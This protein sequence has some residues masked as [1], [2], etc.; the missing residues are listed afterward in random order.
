MRTGTNGPHGMDAQVMELPNSLQGMRRSRVRPRS[1]TM[2]PIRHASIGKA[3]PLPRELR[4]PAQPP[5][6]ARTR[7]WGG[8]AAS[9]RIGRQRAALAGPRRCWNGSSAEHPGARTWASAARRTLERLLRQLACPPHNLSANRKSFSPFLFSPFRAGARTGGLW[10]VGLFHGT[11]SSLGVND[12]G[13]A[14]CC[15]WCTTSVPLTY[16]NCEDVSLCFSRAF[17]SLERGGWGA[18]ALV[19]PWA[20]RTVAAPQTAGMNAGGAS[21]GG[22]PGRSKYTARKVTGRCLGH[23]GVRAS[24]AEATQPVQKKKA[25]MKNATAEAKSP[26]LH[27]VAE[28]GA[29]GCARFRTSATGRE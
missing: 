14:F 8:L 1:R 20:R 28:P 12:Q 22:Q 4:P 29:A 23:Y 21:N 6:A 13:P 24:R 26:A 2:D 11:M 7:W 25:P 17:A 15:I 19:G 27:A 5:D 18:N 10:G 9:G 16:S 3:R